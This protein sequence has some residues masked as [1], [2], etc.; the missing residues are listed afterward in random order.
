VLD[1]VNDRLARCR[2]IGRN[3]GRVDV[4]LVPRRDDSDPFGVRLRHVLNERLI[5]AGRIERNAVRHHKRNPRL[6]RKHHRRRCEQYQ[7]QSS[8]Q[9]HVS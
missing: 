3:D 9:T 2:V 4:V 1:G 8:T 7:Q 6:K 5:G